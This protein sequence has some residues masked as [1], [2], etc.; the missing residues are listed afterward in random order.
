METW[1]RVSSSWISI[2][3]DRLE[4]TQSLGH[5]YLYPRSPLLL[6]KHKSKTFLRHYN[7]YLCVEICQNS[8]GFIKLQYFNFNL[9]RTLL[10]I[11]LNFGFP[12]EVIK[13]GQ[14]NF[15]SKSYRDNWA[16]F[17]NLRNFLIKRKFRKLWILE[18]IIRIS[19]E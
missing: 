6:I 11:Y 9:A 3:R 7:I 5:T 16:T 10:W 1:D 2:S 8:L 15:L 13:F 14:T 4:N 18:I 17:T 19:I 12:N